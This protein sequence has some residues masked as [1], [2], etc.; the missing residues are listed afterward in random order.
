MGHSFLCLQ[1]GF[2]ALQAVQVEAELV[3][4]L[5]QDHLLL[6]CSIEHCGA[7]DGGQD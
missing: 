5:L 4:H 2:L 1:S 3:D 7:V 6:T